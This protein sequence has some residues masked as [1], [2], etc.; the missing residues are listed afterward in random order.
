ME[1]G[2]CFK[3]HK[4]GHRLFHC[5]ELKGKAPMEAPQSKKQRWWQGCST[6]ELEQPATSTIRFKTLLA[7]EVVDKLS[8]SPST[9]AA[10][11][12]TLVARRRRHTKHKTES[13]TC[14]QTFD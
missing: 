14:N 3:C 8:A 7:T 2:L 10:T 1:E 12:A 6:N 5:L 9:T 4:K 13:E 11:P